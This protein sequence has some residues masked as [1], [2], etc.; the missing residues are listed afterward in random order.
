MADQQ[1]NAR[2]ALAVLFGINLM[3]FF[4][5]QV[6]AALGEPIRVEFGLNDTQLGL[7]ATVFTLVYAAVGV[8]L[9]RLTDRWLRTRLIAIGVTFWSVLTAASGLAWSYTSF[10]L[11]RIGVGIGEASCAPAGQSLIGDLYPPERRARA[12]GIFM[13]GL[14]FGL[15]GAYMLSGIIGE[16]WGWRAAFFVACVPGLILA[17]LA[18]LIKE[19]VRGALEV[20]PMAHAA[21]AGSPYRAV[22]GISTLWW[23]ILS[24]LLFNFNSYAVNI[25]QTPFLQRFHE[26]GLKDANNISAISLGLTGAIG[27]LA[28]GWLGDRWRVRRPN[29]RLLLAATSMLLAAPC[30]FMA[31]QQPKGGVLLFTVL[32]GTSSAFTFVYYSTVY[33]AIQ[34]VVA[35]NLRGTAV[36]LYFFAMYVLGASF[37]STILG[38]LSDHFATQAMLAAGA[39]EMAPAFRAEGLHAAMYIIPALMLLCAGSLFGAAR[40]VGADMQRLQ[41]SQRTA[42]VPA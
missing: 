2:Y 23:I 12:M 7:V 16:A 8:P 5:R 4:D 39:A 33:S 38:A 14:P 34:D 36:S 3:N 19:P 17:A 29:G 10:L 28:G 9:G 13:L 1:R 11:T 41:E 20:R 32:M 37:G 24:G 26:L 35:P 6:A 30:V 42:A 15:F 25:F 18:L 40:T 21:H 22:L 31:L 27:L